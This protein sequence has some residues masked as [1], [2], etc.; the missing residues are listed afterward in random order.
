MALIVEDGT[1]VPNAN[2]YQTLAEI[3]A[4]ALARGVTLSAVDSE[5]EPLAIQA[6][7]YL[8]AQRAKYQGNKVEPLVQEL[9]F[10]RDDVKIDCVAFPSDEIPKE[11]QSAENQLVIEL[12]NSVDILPTSEEAFITEEKIG[13][14]TTKYSDTVRTSIEPTM[15]AVDA[16]LEPLFFPCGQKFALTTLRV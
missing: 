12:H 6:M 10:P 5:L 7:D 11:L 3:R 15:T 16:L 1:I 4:Y 9:Q 2:S 8:E 14:I 13:P